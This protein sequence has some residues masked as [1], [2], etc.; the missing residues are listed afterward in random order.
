[1]NSNQQSLFTDPDINHLPCDGDVRY[2]GSIYSRPVADQWAERLLSEIHWQPDEAM[3]YGKRI[4]TRRQ[5]AWYAD[6]LFEYTYSGVNRRAQHW[7]PLIKTLKFDVEQK[8]GQHYN[9][10]LL[11]LYPDGDS[12][13]AWH[14]DDERELRLHG[15]IAA[16]SFGATR[17]FVMKHRA[18]QEKV[19]FA[20]NSGDLLEMR[21]QTQHHWLH[22]V[23]KTKK[24]STPRVSLTF[25]QMM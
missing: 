10:C 21:G 18:T 2:W 23:P 16:L 1:M 12:G 17:R 5:Y 13:M 24:V 25:R 15:S 7:I 20:L 6:E 14:S 11:N 8:T 9:S 4:V 22:S 19:E 3:M